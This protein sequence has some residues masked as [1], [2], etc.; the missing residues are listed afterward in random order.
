MSE[1]GL[2]RKLG[3]TS[4]FNKSHTG[5]QIIIIHML[6]NIPRS[7]GKQTIRFGHITECNMRN[8]F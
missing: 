2:M 6:P 3:L 5:K 1:N 8:E 7:K 4:K